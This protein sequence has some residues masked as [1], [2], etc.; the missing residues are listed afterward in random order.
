MSSREDQLD[1]TVLFA[2]REARLAAYLRDYRDDYHDR[3]RNAEGETPHTH[4]L[5]PAE[6]SLCFLEPCASVTRLLTIWNEPWE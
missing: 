5:V 3:W 6:A 1:L 2:Q 4:E